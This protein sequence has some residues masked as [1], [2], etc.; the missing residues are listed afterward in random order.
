[1]LTL[2]C[3]GKVYTLAVQLRQRGGPVVGADL[4][5]P[6]QGTDPLLHVLL[7]LRRQHEVRHLVHLQLKGILPQT[8]VLQGVFWLVLVRPYFDR[9]VSKLVNFVHL[10]SARL[11]ASVKSPIVSY[12]IVSIL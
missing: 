5:D 10:G 9:Q 6:G 8:V 4:E 12:H 7:A 2:P 1:M 11:V 3:V